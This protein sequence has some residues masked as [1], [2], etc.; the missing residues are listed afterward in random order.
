MYLPRHDESDQFDDDWIMGSMDELTVCRNCDTNENVVC[1]ECGEG[2]A[3][4]Q[5]TASEITFYCLDCHD[6]FVI[7]SRKGENIEEDPVV[8]P[9]PVVSTVS[10]KHYCRHE[11]EPVTLPSGVVIHC[12]ELL[13]NR[14]DIEPPEF[15]LYADFSWRP[16]W[17]NEFIN[18][19]DFQTPINPD[20]ASNQIISLY[21]RAVLGTEVEIGCIGGH[22]RT[23][24]ML[25]C[26]YC[27]DEGPDAVASDAVEWVREHYCHRAVEGPKQAWFISLFQSIVW[28]TEPP[29]KFTTN[30]L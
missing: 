8:V 10:T 12:S 20:M 4:C 17:R 21:G 22:G 19:P 25:A 7:Y 16:T 23:G 14:T 6:E 24:T 30:Q 15:G 9:T 5:C 13:N 28:G 2:F 11:S 3:Y 27:L 1:V 18:W 26:L 29:A